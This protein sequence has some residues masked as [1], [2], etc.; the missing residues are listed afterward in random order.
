MTETA[1]P[2]SRRRG[3]AILPVFR[4]I[5][6]G[7]SILTRR[8][9]ITALGLGAA[10][11]IS[12]IVE[13]AALST[14]IPFIG[15][16]INRDAV[17]T[18]PLAQ[19]LKT[20][21]DLEN[22]RDAFLWMGIAVM[23][24]LGVAFVLRMSVHWLVENFSVKL[25]DRIIRETI[26]GC[27]GAPYLW[28][29][30][31]SGSK[32]AQGI[33]IDTTTVG[34]GIYPVVLEILY[35][36]FMLI[37]GVGMIL[38][39][40]SW[41]AILVFA[42]LIGLGT[43]V[44]ATLN[45][46]ASRVAAQQRLHVL[47]S[48]RLLTEAFGG[49]KLIKASRA[50]YFFAQRCEYEFERGNRTR[51]TLNIVNKSIPTGTLFLGQVGMLGLALALVLSDL[52]IETVVA[53]LTFVLLVLSRVLPSISTL[54]GSFNKLIKAEPFF[55]GFLA[56]SG[57]VSP[58]SAS[59]RPNEADVLR[60]PLDWRTVALHDVAFSYPGSDLPQ[61]A[62]ASLTIER[63]KSY[64]IAGP[65][66]AGKSTLIDLLLGL[67]MPDQG[68]IRIDDKILAGNTVSSWL[69]S[70]AYVPQEPHILDDTVRRNVGFGL[71]DER[72]EDDGVWRALEQA[73]LIE[74]V[75]SWPEG[76]DTRLGDAGS[77][78]S[79]GQR[80]RIAIARAMYR[81]A[82]FLVLDEATN[83]LDTIA[84]EA[85]NRTVHEIQGVTSLIVAHRISALR[86]CD[87]IILMED[88]QIVDIAPYDQLLNSNDLFRTLARE[89]VAA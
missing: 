73:Q 50:E 69:S 71:P 45:P 47:D 38:A 23:V 57:D 21:I 35:G 56:L 34:Q 28:L 27:L 79:G 64:G 22:Y 80:Q 49:R 75:K 10:S 58:W 15:L 66:G 53:H 81:G 63:G 52:P 24:S 72:I 62:T 5:L 87:F 42:V 40:S 16:L 36:M 46:L 84:E 14:T 8:E 25:T 78:L 55:Q 1:S 29:R 51:R 17:T 4:M 26:R 20:V 33:Y 9:R 85:V 18:H 88:G 89:D 83:A 12:S 3:A 2:T 82:N 68:E 54:L 77:R 65:S 31:Q 61:V 30:A 86:A 60:R 6:R 41:Q 59:V 19:A 39:I 74:V 43:S 76:L 7:W 11:L 44:L 32:L 70:I 48:I 37:I 13:L 67:L